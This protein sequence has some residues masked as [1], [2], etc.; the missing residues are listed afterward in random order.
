MNYLVLHIDVEFIAGIVYT[1][2]NTYPVTNGT[3]ELLW[4]YFFNNPH[5]HR[6]SFGKENRTHFNN[7]GL[8]Y[9]G[10]FFEL[11]EN[12]Q[13][14]FIVR[15]IE[16]SAIELLE[17]SGL[18]KTLKE[19]YNSIAHEQPDNIPTLIT[20]SLSI[21]ELAKQKT[22]DYFKN[23]GFQ[24]HSYTIPL[25]ELVC[26]YPFSK[27]DF[28]PN[29]NTTTLL[30]AATNTSLHV[31]KLVFTDN[32]FMIDGKVRTYE[33]KGMD[34]RK[35]ALVRFII[36]EINH[37]TGALSSDKEKEVE[38]EKMEPKAEEWLKRIDAQL[39]NRPFRIVESFSKMPNAK[40]EVFVRKDNIESDTGHY[41]QELMDIFDAFKS[42]NVRGDVAA[43]F[44]LG[45]CFQNSLVKER[46]NKLIHNEKLFI[47]ANKDIQDI[48][49]VY[50]KIDITR[51]ADEEKRIKERA[52]VEQRKQDELR[53]LEDKQ[54]KEQE[55]KERRIADANKK[56]E[57]R[58]EAQK[59]YNRAVEL[60]KEGKLQD[61]IVNV[62]NAIV[63]D[64]DNNEYKKNSEALNKKIEEL[65]RKTEK[66][67]SWLKD[68]EEFIQNSDFDKALKAYK[69]AQETFDS[70]EIRR[71]IIE[72][73]GNIEKRK[74]KEKVINFTNIAEIQLKQGK[75][76]EAINSI[77]KALEIDPANKKAKE[78]LQDIYTQQHNS[79]ID[80]KYK[81][82]IEQADI[83]F[84]ESAVDKATA[85][86]NEALK[87]KPNDKY[88]LDQ[89]A[90][91]KDLI[92]QK[93][94]QEKAAKI[95]EEAG[96]LFESDWIA[97]KVKYKEALKLCPNNESIHDK[98]K[99][100]AD[101]LKVQEDTFSD[102][103]LEATRAEKKGNLSNALT[104]LEKALKIKPDHTDVKSRIK[105]IKFDLEFGTN[106][107]LEPIIQEFPK[108]TD[109][110]D[111]IKSSK[112]TEEDDFLGISKRKPE[113]NAADD[114]LSPKKRHN[115]DDFFNK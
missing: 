22:I 46:F 49:S 42:D 17:Y 7:G 35:R 96:K 8:N 97:A 55:A 101:K 16:K 91:I 50:P 24:I 20:F 92:L 115:K 90:K 43:I 89:I 14:K 73:E 48:L 31:M 93:E 32:Y 15:G 72:I 66:Y 56:E 87:I 58:K 29:S 1:N 70:A 12:E 45:D 25:S 40:K 23:Q 53:A 71:K 99:Q 106:E 4:L 78:I 39:Q 62:K 112:S 98:I 82:I 108:K 61:A 34:P 84:K 76:E 69:Y 74:K 109:N 75:F 77:N 27:K 63:L 54:R 2:G 94:N 83:L 6:I 86:Y 28:I 80:E 36:N 95:I 52:I 88:C 68:A 100:C 30:L 111:F 51:Y 37:A 13:E 9:Y 3:E 41:I 47:Y 18:L 107:K 81:G 19:K 60:E 64:K 10:K 11:I 103:F 110:D 85:K 114:F 104:F 33:G 26:Y 57:N 21:S 113:K 102:L 44:L 79:E 105:K 59:L 38:C 67:K 5:Q 65:N